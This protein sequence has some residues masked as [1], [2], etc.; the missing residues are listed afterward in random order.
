[1]ESVIINMRDEWLDLSPSSTRRENL[2]QTLTDLCYDILSQ[3][4][5][6][7]E[8][9]TLAT[10]TISIIYG[11]ISSD[12]GAGAGAGTDIPS[13]KRMQELVNQFTSMATTSERLS[14]EQ[15]RELD[16]LTD[17][18]KRALD[19]CSLGETT[20]FM[21]ELS[22]LQK[23]DPRVPIALPPTPEPTPQER[24]GKLLDDRIGV[25]NTEFHKLSKGIHD[26]CSR[27]IFETYFT[28]GGRVGSI[29][30]NGTTI[31]TPSRLIGLLNTIGEEDNT[32]IAILDWDRFAAATYTQLY[33]A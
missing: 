6:S 19:D 4:S 33:G 18:C 2:S 3:D 12:T 20:R 28:N 11:E 16:Q 24:I 27:Q 32:S 31:T 9:H 13:L 10:S 25:Y 17:K 21:I 30:I 8:L 29:M 7:G 22:K 26:N 23:L 14:P 15:L 5:A 1:M